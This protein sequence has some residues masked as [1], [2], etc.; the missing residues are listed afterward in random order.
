MDILRLLACGSALALP[1]SASAVAQSGGGWQPVQHQQ[2]AFADFE[3]GAAVACIGDVNGDLIPDTL[4]GSPGSDSSGMTA[5]GKVQIRSG[6]DG[7]QIDRVLG[8]ATG[9]RLGAAVAN[10][11]DVTGD[12]IDD[13]LCGAPFHDGG[14]A[15]GGA[16]YLYNGATRSLV[17]TWL[18]AD[19]G[20]HFGASVAGG[21][22]VDGDNVPDVIIGAPDAEFGGMTA[23]GRVFVYS[24]ATGTLIRSHDGVAQDDRLGA[25]AVLLDD[26]NGDLK[27]DYVLGSPGS[28]L[29]PGLR[30]GAIEGFSG[31][32]G[33]SL[34]T[35]SGGTDAAEFGAS[36]ARLADR[37]GDGV[38]EFIVGAPGATGPL[39]ATYGA[40]RIYLGDTGEFDK[41][42]VP[43]E[44]DTRYGT[45]VAGAGDVDLDGVE[46]ILVGAPF[47]DGG[48]IID[49]GTLWF[50]SGINGF[51]SRVADGGGDNA[52]MGSAVACA[53]DLD[54][55][56]RPAIMVGSAGFNPGGLASAGAVDIY[57]IDPWMALDI[58]SFS[59]AAG[60]VINFAVDFPTS[61]ANSAYEIFASALGTGPTIR[62]GVKIP[63][64]MD[65]LLLRMHRSPPAGWIGHHGVLNASGDA[66]STLT[67]PAGLAANY[68]GRTLWF[69]AVTMTGGAPTAASM[70]SPVTVMP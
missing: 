24:G 61:S 35:R 62:G 27:G 58:D 41:Q 7:A 37:D 51:H 46:D 9:D 40:A 20:G 52:H 17:R 70:P 68:V 13:F 29:G 45:S 47:S 50:V 11:G 28:D 38:N 42:F 6:A 8:A 48:T 36:L 16:V 1:L 63:L 5:N 44:T 55:D 12:G 18:G 69:A 30:A 66:A 53:G 49:C 21:V 22:D 3:L 26:V 32:D 59:S 34:Y 23:A 14:A 2:S 57:E 33:A 56:R 65:Y 43:V 15:D 31:A 10:A 64:T 25:A 19:A 39:G 60:G 67:L 54:G 4:Q